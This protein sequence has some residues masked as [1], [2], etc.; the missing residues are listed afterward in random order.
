[1]YEVKF[2]NNM[3]EFL[4]TTQVI[5]LLKDQMKYIG[6]PKTNEELMNTIKQTFN[7]ENSKLF[8]ISENDHI[9]G[10]TFF[11]I[12]IGM[13]S[14]GKYLWLNEMHIHKDY[15]GKGYGKILFNEMVKWCEENKIVRILGISD[16]T[17][18]RTENF[19]IKRGMDI[20]EKDIIS[21]NI[22]K[23]DN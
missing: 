10:F 4:E 1:M 17:E 3:E 8:V 15:R 11:N 9:I 13:E 20:H 16:S 5:L 7:N 21:M 22:K 2:I 19:Y 12:C 18:A 23:I 6:S 14:S